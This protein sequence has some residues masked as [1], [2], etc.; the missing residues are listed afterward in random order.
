MNFIMPVPELD[1]GINA[2]IF[3]G[4]EKMAMSSTAM[5]RKI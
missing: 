4:R 1:P 5:M 2:G 3:F